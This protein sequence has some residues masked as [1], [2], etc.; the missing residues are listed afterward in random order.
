M[1]LPGRSPLV[2]LLMWQFRQSLVGNVMTGL[3]HHLRLPGIVLAAIVGTL[4]V[5]GEVSACSTKAASNCCPGPAKSACCCEPAT[6]QPR[7]ESA[8]RGT[9]HSASAVRFAPEPG[10][11]CRSGEP[12]GPAS[13]SESP[14]SQHRTDQGSPRILE[15]VPDVRPPIAITRLVL[16]TES[17]PRTP[18]YLR[19]SR[20]II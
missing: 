5:V 13:K 4:S 18:L 6:G 3:R 16:P 7:S 15:L 20:L 12:T 10:C 11:E 8:E 1:R 19:T 9:V 14:P 17:P 2:Q